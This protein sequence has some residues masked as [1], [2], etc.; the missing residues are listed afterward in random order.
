MRFCGLW[1]NNA[2][3][4]DFGGSG[5]LWSF[6]VG[7]SRFVALNRVNLKDLLAGLSAPARFCF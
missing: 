1:F 4:I 7:S 2:G 5:C 3:A 6:L